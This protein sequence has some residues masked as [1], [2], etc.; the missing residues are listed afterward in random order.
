[1][2]EDVAEILA[3]R[4]HG[5]GLEL[6]VHVDPELPELLLGDSVRIR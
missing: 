6:T 3:E 4:A 5:K 2:I 1:M